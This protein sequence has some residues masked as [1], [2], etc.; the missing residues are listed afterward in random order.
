MTGPGGAHRVGRRLISRRGFIKVYPYHLDLIA[1]LIPD[2]CVSAREVWIA[3]VRLANE[4]R[5]PTFSREIALIAHLAHLGYRVTIDLLH[6]LERI[7]LLKIERAR[8]ARGQLRSKST[9][10]LV[11]YALSA[12][13]VC[14][15]SNASRADR[16]EEEEK[17]PRADSGGGLKPPPPSAGTKEEKNGDAW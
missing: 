16:L 7:G 11:P 5:G 17:K 4:E 3:C 8:D 1:E 12:D 6:R 15:G 14:T 9:Y 10:T 2:R 13:P